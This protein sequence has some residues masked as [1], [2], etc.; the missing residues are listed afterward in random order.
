M[1]DSSSGRGEKQGC[2]DG[3]MVRECR[4]GQY[5]FV[6]QFMADRMLNVESRGGRGYSDQM[7]SKLSNDD[8]P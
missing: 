1:K 4:H 3:S 7:T 2:D 8:R 6:C 5:L